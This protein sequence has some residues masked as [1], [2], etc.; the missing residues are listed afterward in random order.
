MSY[1]ELTLR[2]FRSMRA[3]TPLAAPE[4]GRRPIDLPELLSLSARKAKGG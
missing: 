2:S 3:T 4:P 1:Q